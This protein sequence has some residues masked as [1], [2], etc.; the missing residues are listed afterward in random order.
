M[1]FSKFNTSEKEKILLIRRP[2]KSV[3]IQPKEM[4]QTVQEFLQKS[5][6]DK[7]EQEDEL[8]FSL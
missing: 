6:E 3:T 1:A 7:K 2:R 5:R 4:E 8:T